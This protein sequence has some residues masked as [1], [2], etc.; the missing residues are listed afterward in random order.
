MKKNGNVTNYTVF[1]NII[2][3][4]LSSMHFRHFS[5]RLLIQLK[6]KSSV[7]PSSLPLLDSFLERF[8]VRIADST[9]VR[10]QIALAEYWLWTILTE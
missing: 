5:A 4:E 9:K 1:F 3:I 2:T 10:L 8:I 6:Q 7:C